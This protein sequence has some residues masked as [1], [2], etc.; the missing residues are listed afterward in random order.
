[1]PVFWLHI[2]LWC[3]ICSACCGYAVRVYLSVNIV[4]GLSFIICVLG[5]RST[6]LPDAWGDNP[7]VFIIL[8]LLN[9]MGHA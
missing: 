3:V 2:L 6:V 8:C 7:G 1:M 4:S 9:R 5:T